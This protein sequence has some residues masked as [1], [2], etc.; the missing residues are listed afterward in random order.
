MI[1]EQVSAVREHVI[2]QCQLILLFSGFAIS[3]QYS[4]STCAPGSQ[5]GSTTIPLGETVV[6][7]PTTGMNFVLVFSCASGLTEPPLPLGVQ[8]A[9]YM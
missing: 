4:S 2:C 3:N 8:Y 1:A 9:T 6:E 5:T 7:D